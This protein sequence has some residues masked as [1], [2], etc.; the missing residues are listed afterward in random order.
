MPIEVFYIIFGG[1]AALE[2]AIHVFSVVVIVPIFE[3]RLPFDQTSAAPGDDA[4]RISM[5][6]SDGLTL[7]GS[8][9]RPRQD[10]LGLVIFC[11]EFR[12]THGTAVEYCQGLLE[13]GFAVLAFDFRGQGESD[14]MPGYE[15]LHWLTDFE[16]QDLQSVMK[17]V[18]SRSDLA[19]LPIGLMGVSRGASAAL[20]V[21]AVDQQIQCVVADSAFTSDTLMVLYAARWVQYYTPKYFR[22]PEWHLRISCRLA[23]QVSQLRRRVRH[24]RLE[25]LLPGLHRR[26]V[27]LIAGERDSYVPAESSR[28]IQKKIGPDCAVWYVPE[29]RHNSARQARPEEYDERLVDL[30][31][32][33][34]PLHRL[35]PSAV[36]ARSASRLQPVD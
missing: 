23:L 7:R 20:A 35:P 33:M 5:P 12:G 11:P 25:R 31:L 34:V 15:P 6:T 19:E 32:N 22:L 1:I 36:P 2:V 13:A 29:A 28:R 14:A 17:Y 18:R 10:P 27:L 24:P 8:L 21:A 30:F 4:E 3:R 26:S 9:S 16:V